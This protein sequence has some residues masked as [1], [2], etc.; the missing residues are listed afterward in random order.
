LSLLLR[1]WLGVC[2]ILLAACSDT[3]TPPKKLHPLAGTY[4]L[5][6]T[7][8]SIDSTVQSGCTPPAIACIRS[9][10]ISAV[11]LG[12]T[13]TIPGDTVMGVD[14]VHFTNVTAQANGVYGCG[15]SGCA[16]GSA[17]YISASNSTELLPE[18]LPSGEFIADLATFSCQC[19]TI[20]LVLDGLAT[21]DSISGSI[22]WFPVSTAWGYSGTFAAKR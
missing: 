15:S 16:F 4:V 7:I 3:P 8:T 6:T 2:L 5:K 14:A 11:S 22:H 1:T 12:G 13:L 19:S 20:S 17:G 9:H 21:A 10:P 18:L